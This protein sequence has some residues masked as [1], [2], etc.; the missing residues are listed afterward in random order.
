ME[1]PKK[2]VFHIVKNWSAAG[3]ELTVEGMIWKLPLST[4][5]PDECTNSFVSAWFRAKA[6]AG[7]LVLAD[8]AAAWGEAAPSDIYNED[9]PELAVDKHVEEQA[10]DEGDMEP[11]APEAEMEPPDPLAP[12]AEMEPPAPDADTAAATDE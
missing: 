10:A 6:L 12:E 9:A 4:L 2:N 11:P 8:R 5:F 3:A 1:D 7:P